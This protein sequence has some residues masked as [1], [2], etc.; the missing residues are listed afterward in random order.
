M[1]AGDLIG[2]FTI[3]LLEQSGDHHIIGARPDAALP[4]T[5][6][7]LVFGMVRRQRWNAVQAVEGLRVLQL[8]HERVQPLFRK[9]VGQ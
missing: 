5:T 8:G 4:V 7:F 1:I 2:Q 9:D 3:A 6:V